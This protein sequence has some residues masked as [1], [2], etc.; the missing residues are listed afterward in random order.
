MAYGDTRLSQEGGEV[1][2]SLLFLWDKL[3]QGGAPA[4]GDRATQELT[5]LQLPPQ[6]ESLMI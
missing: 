6:K 1:A 3:C 2:G 4:M 5:V